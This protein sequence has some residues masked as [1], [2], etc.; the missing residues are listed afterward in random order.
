MPASEESVAAAAAFVQ[1]LQR[2][3][4]TDPQT[5]A[6]IEAVFKLMTARLTKTGYKEMCKQARAV[7]AK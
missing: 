3:G 4:E 6:T 7:F 1:D 5:Q 2:L